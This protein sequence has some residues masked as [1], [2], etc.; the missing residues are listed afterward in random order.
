MQS[1][2]VFFC[3][4]CTKEIPILLHNPNMMGTIDGASI[5]LSMR[6]RKSYT[7]AGTQAFNTT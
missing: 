2:Q 1:N 3:I 6:K 5:A 4:D 7:R